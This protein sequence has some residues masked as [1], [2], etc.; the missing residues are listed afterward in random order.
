MEEKNMTKFS[1]I[2]LIICLCILCL[3]AILLGCGYF[4][5]GSLLFN[6]NDKLKITT[7]SNEYYEYDLEKTE[8]DS[9]ENMNIS[10]ACSSITIKPSDNYYI[11]YH[12]KTNSSSINP[13]YSTTNNTLNFTDTAGNTKI[14]LGNNKGFQLTNYELILYL[15]IDQKDFE[16][17]NVSITS[18][19]GDLTISDL[20]GASL[21]V[22][23]D[24]GD[25]SFTNLTFDSTEINEEL[26][27]ILIENSTLGITNLSNSCGDIELTNCTTFDNIIENDLENVNISLNDNTDNYNYELTTSFGEIHLDGELEGSS[28]S[29]TNNSSANLI[30]IHSSCGD[31][32]IK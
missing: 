24:C 16:I 2:L 3:G 12:Y 26:G 8:I 1:K 22:E 19:L 32:D 4:L 31:I 17:N 23:L 9:F 29:V 30:K 13:Q 25:I 20:S 27:N 10:T 11:E 28:Y 7:P 15:P 14:D 21:S 5:G 6:V 18:N